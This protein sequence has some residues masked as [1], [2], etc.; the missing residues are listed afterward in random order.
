MKSISLTAILHELVKDAPSGLPAKFIAERIG[1]D[2]NTLMSELSRQPNHKLGADLVLPL[3]KL[4]G[5]I[6]PLDVMA[7]EMGV[8][9]VALPS[10]GE[11]GHLLVHRQCMVAVQEFGRLMGATADALEDGTITPAERDAIAAKGYEALAAIVAL[12]KAVEQ[13]VERP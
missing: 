4:T 11:G 3:M 9:C 7:A 2:Y 8:V 6:Q 13:G 1:R 12:L 5:S 10:A